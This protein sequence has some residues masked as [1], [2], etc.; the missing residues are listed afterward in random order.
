MWWA[1]AQSDDWLQ[2]VVP[3]LLFKWLIVKCLSDFS[4]LLC[5]E[6]TSL[7]KNLYLA[8]SDNMASFKKKKK[9]I[10]T[11]LA[12]NNFIFM[13][14]NSSSHYDIHHTWEILLKFIPIVQYWPYFFSSSPCL[15]STSPEP[16][17]GRRALSAGVLLSAAKWCFSQAFTSTWYH[18]AF[19][20]LAFAFNSVCLNDEKG[21]YTRDQP[22][23]HFLFRPELHGKIGVSKWLCSGK[24]A[25]QRERFDESV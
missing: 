22:S 12:S 7:F 15:K 8:I 10:R 11:I 6:S 25:N 17:R 18:L 1:H 20:F 4:V 23:A 21:K 19:I 14:K 9:Y 16:T 2:C 3:F 5:P 24:R 13:H